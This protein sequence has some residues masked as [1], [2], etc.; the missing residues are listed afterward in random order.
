MTPRVGLHRG[1]RAKR[2][3][4]PTSKPW[5]RSEVRKQ[6]KAMAGTETL[7]EHCFWAPRPASEQ[8]VSLVFRGRPQSRPAWP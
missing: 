2:E 8:R 5:E 4:R 6:K 7:K 1:L 3:I